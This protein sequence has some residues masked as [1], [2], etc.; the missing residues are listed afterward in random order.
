[1]RASTTLLLTLAFSLTTLTWADDGD[2]KK[3]KKAKIPAL[4]FVGNYDGEIASVEIDSDRIVLKIRDVVPKWVPNNNNPNNY[5]P[6]RLGMIN[7]RLNNFNG[8]NGGT[9]VPQ[10]QQKDVPINLSPDVKVRI[11][12][13]PPAANAK[14]TV[15]STKKE[16]A[17]TE[18]EKAEKDP[19]YKLGGS[20]GKKSELNKGQLVRV[21]MG[22][23]NDK[24]N[25][26]IYAMAIFVVREGSPA[27]TGR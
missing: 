13:P 9:Y 19:D 4:T 16:K 1:M 6:G 20:P 25:P 18:K 24:V 15:N 23:N 5:V 27:P 21:A 14:K 8:N 7:N 22:R 17:P 12:T 11:M 3:E 10:E 26:Q 2:E